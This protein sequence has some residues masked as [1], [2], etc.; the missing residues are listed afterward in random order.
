MNFVK[1]VC[2]STSVVATNVDTVHEMIQRDGHITYRKN[3]TSLGINIKV[4]HMILHDHL[5]VR[6]VR[7]R[8]IPHNL[9]EKQARVK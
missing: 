7:S 9:I 8:W 5:S 4:I 1:V 3:Q 2:P 6:K